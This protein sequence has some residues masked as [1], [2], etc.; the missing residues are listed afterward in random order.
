MQKR[1][2]AT[3]D[4]WGEKKKQKVSARNLG[5]GHL[6]LLWF[7]AWGGLDQSVWCAGL[8]DSRL[9]ALV[10][11]PPSLTF[12]CLQ[13]HRKARKRTVQ[14]GGWLFLFYCFFFFRSSEA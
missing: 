11:L 7:E 3:G 5:H 8:V 4:T 10:G 1:H 13:E 2:H 14:V 12:G 9:A 6:N